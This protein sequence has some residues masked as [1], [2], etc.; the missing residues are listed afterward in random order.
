MIVFEHPALTLF[1]LL[2]AAAYLVLPPYRRRRSAL[3]VPF[4]D[5]L[6]KAAGVSG[7]SAAAVSS[8]VE[9]IVLLT[10]LAL[11]L[12]ALAQPRYIGAPV[13]NELPMRD[14]LI[15]VDLSGSMETRDFTTADGK[16]ISRLD[17]VKSVLHDFLSRRNGE[18]VGLIFFG[19]AAFVQAPF[20]QD[21]KA[22]GRLLD[23]AQV[24]MAGPQTALGDAIGL[25]A[26]LFRE[27][28]VSERMLIVLSDGDDTHSKV[29]PK[30]AAKVAAQEDV[31][32]FTIAMG[33]PK[34]AGETPMDTDTLKAIAQRT[35]G[36]FYYAMDRDELETIYA[37]IDRLKPRLVKQESF[38]P[39]TELYPYPLGGF[40]I[41]LL[42][43]GF[44]R[45]WRGR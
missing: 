15:A 3:R 38:R 37:D 39:T 44:W 24:G 9:R 1:A 28:N 29:P 42:L 20:T 7:A 11:L 43:F 6:R 22:L 40:V 31:Q 18:R 41:L 10:A 35:G 19:T 34:H 8:R 33:D 2:P 23:E 32:I 13:T 45:Q 14:L 12:A 26:K 17:A 5:R 21:L 27:S 30:E 16:K 25:C 36:R 4:L